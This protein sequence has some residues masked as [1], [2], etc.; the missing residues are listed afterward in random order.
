MSI[1]T[2]TGD[3]GMTGLYTGERIAKNSPRVNAYGNVDELNSALAL[4]RASSKNRRVTEIVFELQKMNMSLMAELASIKANPYIT[5][6]EVGKLDAFID[7]LEQKLPVLSAFLTPGETL[8]GGF[9]DLSRTI[10]RRTE[11]SVLDLAKEETV[12]KEVRIFLNRLS[13]LC[14]L[15]MRLEENR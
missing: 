6:G 2:K 12:T 5:A 8:C 10:A 11:R 9:L 1:T 4:A 3:Q 13:D 7:E 15:L 14:F